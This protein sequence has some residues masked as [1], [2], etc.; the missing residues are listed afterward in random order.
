MGEYTDYQVYLV[1]LDKDQ[2]IKLKLE[3]PNSADFDLVCVH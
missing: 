2:N 3:V 1:N